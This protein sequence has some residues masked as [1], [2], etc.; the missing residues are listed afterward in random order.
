M[1]KNVSRWLCQLVFPLASVPTNFQH[2]S[3][4]WGENLGVKISLGRKCKK[5]PTFLEF[6]S[7]VSCMNLRGILI[8]IYIARSQNLRRD[9]LSEL[10]RTLNL[11]K[12]KS[13][14]LLKHCTF[15]D[16]FTSLG[17]QSCLIV[18]MFLFYFLRGYVV[19]LHCGFY[20]HFPD[21]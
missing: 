11:I 20:L 15:D 19:L 18:G 9:L 7:V 4:E 16:S 17:S 14:H 6:C 3:H 13:K 10:C 21:N 8:K 5:V 1:T 12:F 2:Q